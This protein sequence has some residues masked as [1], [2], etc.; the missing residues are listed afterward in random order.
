VAANAWRIA[1]PSD[2]Q[3]QLAGLPAALAVLTRA[4]ALP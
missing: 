1:N 4:G 3:A 2:L